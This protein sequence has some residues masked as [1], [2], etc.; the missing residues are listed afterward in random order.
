MKAVYLR[1]F[2]RGF[3]TNSSSTHSVIYKNKDE[4]FNDLN[5]FEMDYYGRHDETIAA[6][7]EA[8]IKYVAA[9][10]CWYGKLFEI[11]CKYYP[12]MAQY[13]D[14]I[15]ERDDYDKDKF[16]MCARGL[17]YFPKSENLEASIDYLCNIIDNDEIVIIGG[18]DELDFVYDTVEGHE[19][20]PEPDDVIT[21]SLFD[22]KRP[23]S[24]FKNGNYWIGYG[25]NGK[26]RFKT[27]NK[28]CIPSYPELVDL[29]ITNKCFWNCP[30][31]FMD[32]NMKEKEA[33]L[34]FL[35]TTISNLLAAENTTYRRCIEFSVGGGNILLYPHLEELFD[36]MHENGCIINTTIN[37]KDC[38]QIIEDEKLLKIFRKYVTAV[39]VS[40]CSREDIERVEDF[41]EN[42]K[43]DNKIYMDVVI[44]MIPELL[45]AKET[46]EIIDEL[47]KMKYYN[48]LFLGYKI[49]GRGATQE[50]HKFNEEDLKILFN[51]LWR[52]SIDTT[53]ANSYKEWIDANYETKHTVTLNEGEYS[54]YIDGVEQKAYKSSYQLDKSYNLSYQ[55]YRET[56]E[57][58]YSAVNAFN[59][60]RRDCGFEIF[61]DN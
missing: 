47:Y 28:E 15:K 3:A 36:Y 33:D 58:Y 1:N 41:E 59:E 53:F 60:I 30:F 40:V 20:L 34:L 61:K 55:R 19:T 18:S 7:K 27:D 48:F 25:Y 49:N 6:S 17:L 54:M 9:N 8:K 11:M 14:L 2:R 13:T 46:R 35:K 16:G 29:R 57:K 51:G 26:I 12:Q 4:M 21:Y 56:G 39:G 10:I 42:L 22:K 50:Y 52:T 32:S 37:A 45:G 31:C 44:H 5:I 43:G 38:K 23:K 24:V